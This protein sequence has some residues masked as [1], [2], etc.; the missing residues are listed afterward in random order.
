[1]ITQSLQRDLSSKIPTQDTALDDNRN[2]RQGHSDGGNTDGCARVGL[3][4]NQP[5]I[6]V[7][8][9]QVVENSGELEQAQISVGELSIELVLDTKD[10]SHRS[11][12]PPLRGD[13]RFERLSADGSWP[14]RIGPAP[15]GL[16]QAGP[17]IYG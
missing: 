9:V 14:L 16:H 6:R 2:R 15:Q 3:V 4:A 1:Q 8:F 13:P 12:L 7:G 10:F 11:R 17:Q 5:V